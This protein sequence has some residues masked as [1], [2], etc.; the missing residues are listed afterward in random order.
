MSV[1]DP[2]EAVESKT[3][4]AD[5]AVTAVGLRPVDQLKTLT[6]KA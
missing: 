1:H 4:I 3:P 6:A 2:R 5:A